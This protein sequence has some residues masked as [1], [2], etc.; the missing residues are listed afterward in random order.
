VK[1]D[2]SGNIYIADN[3]NNRVVE[4]PV[5]CTSASCQ[6]TVGFGLTNPS[7]LAIDG[8]GN[9]F[10]AD[11]SNN[12]VVEVP[13]GC[14]SS[15]CQIT[16]VSG[17]N[18]PEGVLVDGVGNVYVGDTHN[19]RVLEIPAG[20]TTSA[21]Q[22]SLGVGYSHPG[23][24]AIDAAGNLFVTD[25]FNNRVVKLPAGCTGGPCQTTV[26][27][28]LN[29]P[30][31]VAVDA[32]GDVFI[33][34]YGDSRAIEVPA[35]C[36]S[37]SC[38]INIG[39]GLNQPAGI[40][41]DSLGDV[42][43]TDTWNFRVLEFVR[44]QVPSLSF[45]TIAAGTSSSPQ[46]ITLKNIGDLALVFSSIAASSNFAVDPGTTTCSTASALALGASCN[47]GV[48]CSPKVGGNLSGALTLSDNA[49][50]GVTP[51]Q[52]VALSCT[53]TAPPQ[54]TSAN[55]TTF[56]IGQSGSFTV[57][58]N[59]GPTPSL[60]MSGALP[61]GV[62]FVDN[63]NGTGTLAGTPTASGTFNLTVT[64][65]NTQGSAT[66][67]FTLTVNS[68]LTFS[69][70]SVNFGNVRIYN[71]YQ[72]TVTVTNTSSSWIYINGASIKPGTA[73]PWDYW[74]YNYCSGWLGPNWSCQ[75][76]VNLW[77]DDLGTRT[78]T[79]NVYDSA[80][81]SPQQVSITANVVNSH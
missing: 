38:Q 73:D 58:S 80:P 45:G 71:Q 72:S 60:T 59:G 54:I 30:G 32:A 2:G 12:R 10:I 81:G 23:T 52:T 16:I 46:T 75:I 64:A 20:C 53:A 77:A 1:T 51:T 44:S 28:G 26:G 24:I 57:T 79:L 15:S 35:G 36:T 49:L 42:F 68:G 11:T 70:S 5:G 50:N 9:V 63:G 39:S 19:N 74:A 66:Q 22:V 69:P 48:V 7:S 3:V 61:A 62:N 41:V 55:N 33:A 34:D 78:A 13:A 76:F 4:V 21:C 25:Y 31:G 27:V 18:T 14:T 67:A 43:V 8:A 56:T 47:V 29:G 40:G 17:L 6:T 37:A 65:T